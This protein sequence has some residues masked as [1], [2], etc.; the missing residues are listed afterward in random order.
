M[1]EFSKPPRA[2]LAILSFF[3]NQPDFPAVAGDLSE[4]YQQRVRASGAAAAKRWYWRET[5]RN[6]WALTL[7]EVAR[8]PVLTAAM[9]LA[10]IL[11]VNLVSVLYFVL[12][13]GLRGHGA[14]WLTPAQWAL[15][16]LLQLIG[17][18][19]VGRAGGS[20][21]HGRECALALTYTAV[22]LLQ[23][24][25]GLIAIRRLELHLPAALEELA[26]L[27]YILRLAGFWLAT[28]SLRQ[29]SG[30]RSRSETG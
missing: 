14:L 11:A 8:T 10:C 12:I 6:A 25:A 17:A 4:E 3:A 9:A 19:V 5:F 7:R 20:L 1:P 21:L 16:L 15:V 13:P 23:A 2:P 27:A 24:A 28:L 29:G 30:A 22:S 26:L 18:F